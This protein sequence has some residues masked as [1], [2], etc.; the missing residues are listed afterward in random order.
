MVSVFVLSVLDRGFESR[1]GQTKDYRIDI[2]S[3]STK[4]AALSRKSKDCFAR[5]QDNV[6]E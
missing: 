3:F 5:N 4:K 1:S 6:S 2:F